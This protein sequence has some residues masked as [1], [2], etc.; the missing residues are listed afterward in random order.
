MTDVIVDTSSWIASFRSTA[1]PVLLKTMKELIG[2][3][4]ILVPG[5]IQAELLRGAKNAKEVQSLHSVLSSQK[6]LRVEES[7]WQRLGYFTNQLFLQGINVPLPDAYI[8]L[9]AMENDVE[10]LHCDRHF[11]LIAGKTKL[12]VLKLPV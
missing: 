11:D 6:Y 4:C 12:K 10:L 3:G 7:F 1:Q 8:A 2:G 5:I 9:L